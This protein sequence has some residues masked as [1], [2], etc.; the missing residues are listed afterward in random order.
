VQIWREKRLEGR[1]TF[2]VAHR[3]STIVR[4]D[5]IL[6]IDEGRILERGTHRERLAAHGTYARRYEQFIHR[7]A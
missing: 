3:L 7:T 5:C 6:V 4:A 2:V 1:T